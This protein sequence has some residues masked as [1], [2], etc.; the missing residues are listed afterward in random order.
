M[1]NREQLRARA[2]FVTASRFGDVMAF[3]KQG[4][5]LEA[6]R[7]YLGEVV[8]ER[9]SGEPCNMLLAP[10]LGWGNDVEPYGKIAY[11]IST[12][13]VLQASDFVK[14]PSIEWVG[15]TPDALVGDDGGYE[16]KCPV[17]S[18][19]HLE[20]WLDGMPKNHLPQIQGCMWVT[21][22]TWWE[23][24]SFD[25][26]MPP[27]LRLYRQR[28]ERDDAYIA[29]LEGHVLKFLKEIEGMLGRLA[30]I[31]VTSIRRAA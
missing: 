13:N 26:R 14:H 23:F 10:S 28:I 24:A 25:P 2:G 31:G 27:H 5:P 29:A 21:G 3:G 30:F 16:S 6:R 7:K 12:G 19:V 8:T 4:Q 9:L 22:R 17:N 1:L 20:T 15:C 18:L 11:E